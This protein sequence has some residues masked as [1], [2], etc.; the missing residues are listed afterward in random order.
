[1][2]RGW[3][4]ELLYLLTNRERGFACTPPSEGPRSPWG[5]QASSG[6]RPRANALTRALKHTLSHLAHVR[7]QPQEPKPPALPAGA[8]TACLQIRL[9]TPHTLCGDGDGDVSGAQRHPLCHT[10]RSLPRKASSYPAAQNPT[11]PWPAPA[12]SQHPPHPSVSRAL[13]APRPPASLCPPHR[14]PFLSL[15][16]SLPS[17]PFAVDSHTRGTSCRPL[18]VALRECSL[19]RLAQ[20]W[21]TR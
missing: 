8:A 12:A 1:M 4:G 16:L 11:R 9:W 10:H 7:P 2:G 3:R 19:S 18:T 6:Q 14:P 15:S 21:L 13:E 5:S 20:S 17:S